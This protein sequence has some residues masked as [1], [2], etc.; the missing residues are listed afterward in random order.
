[1]TGDVADGP[2]PILVVHRPGT[3]VQVGGDIGGVILAFSC[4]GCHLTYE[5]AWWDGRSCKSEWLQ[6]CEFTVVD[7]AAACKARVGFGP[8]GRV[9]ANPTGSIEGTVAGLHACRGD[10]PKSPG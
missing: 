6:P 8:V 1:M 7:D 5:V 4:R 9:G 2:D 3:K 10:D